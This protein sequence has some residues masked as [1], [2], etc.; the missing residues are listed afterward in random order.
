MQRTP[1]LLELD[2]PAPAEEVGYWRVSTGRDQ[3]PDMQIAAMKR[4]GI[5][6]ANIFGDVKSG[7]KALRPGLEK[8][9]KLMAGRPGWSLVVWKLDR[10]G[11]DTAELLRLDGEFKAEGWNLISL[12]ESID[13]RT[14]MGQAFFGMLA[15]FAQFESDTTK[16]R[17]RAGM[18]RARE[19]GSQVGRETR[20][21]AA[22]FDQMERLILSTRAH[23]LS[24]GRIA[25]RFKITTPALSY[26]FPGWR[27]KSKKERLAW[28]KA[29]PFPIKRKD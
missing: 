10:L 21:T 28:R 19:N 23:P 9:L 26:H 29:H 8:A 27:S 3:T 14:A 1:K 16:E 13:T 6:D 2:Q 5:P 4:R 15:V 11:R 12:T 7:R 17:T 22:Q 24:L 20:F 25:H 18:A